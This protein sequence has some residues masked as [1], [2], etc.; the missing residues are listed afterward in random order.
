VSASWQALSIFE[1]RPRY[2]DEASNGA[3]GNLI[4]QQKPPAHQGQT[5]IAANFVPHPAPCQQAPMALHRPLKRQLLCSKES[6]LRM[7]PSQKRLR[8]QYRRGS[9]P[10]PSLSGTCG[11]RR[12]VGCPRA[13]HH[14]Q[15][16][17]ANQYQT[18]IPAISDSLSSLQRRVPE[19]FLCHA[20]S[21]A[22]CVYKSL[23]WCTDGVNP[24]QPWPNT[25][26]GGCRT[27]C[28]TER[29][30]PT[31]G[32]S[33]ATGWPPERRIAVRRAPQYKKHWL[34]AP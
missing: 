30:P 7:G 26:T 27:E 5:L 25:D 4:R 24:K 34:T 29:S 20:G 10:V 6:G 32:Q 31:T 19:C 2:S 15:R 33:T 17:P 9:C 22:S 13:V 23:T 11:G 12:Q 18:R 1:G 21:K 16:C 28:S 14:A 8:W 3:W